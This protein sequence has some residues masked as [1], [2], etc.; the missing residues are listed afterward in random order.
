VLLGQFLGQVIA[1]GGQ[2]L[3][4]GRGFLLPQLGVDGQ[5]QLNDQVGLLKDLRASSRTAARSG[6]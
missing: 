3:V 5:E 6:R 4:D 2:V 1:E